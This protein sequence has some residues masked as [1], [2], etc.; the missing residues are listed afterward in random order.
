MATVALLSIEEY[1]ATGYHPDCDYIDGEVQERN[2]GKYDH[3]KLQK[4]LI[5]YLGIRELEWQVE[6]LPEQ[7][8]R[9]GPT[10]VRIPDV[11]I[12]SLEQVIEQTPTKPPLV[13]IEILSEGDTLKST[14]PRLVDYHRFGVPEIWVFDPAEREAWIFNGA[15]YEP[16]LQVLTVPGTSIEIVVSDLFA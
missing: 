14:R 9:V 7:R 3:S 1:Y 16:A 6:V 11:C 5:L 15:E 2:V 13:C 12:F 10:R 4:A 8:L